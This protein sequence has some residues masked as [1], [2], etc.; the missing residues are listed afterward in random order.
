MITVNSTPSHYRLPVSYTGEDNGKITA[1]LV[2]YKY[3]VDDGSV[4]WHGTAGEQPLLGK[5]AG[6]KTEKF[7]ITEYDKLCED[8][9]SH[10]VD[11]D[12]LRWVL[13]AYVMCPESD[14]TEEAIKSLRKP[15]LRFFS[16]AGF[17][18]TSSVLVARASE[19]ERC[20]KAL[21]GIAPE[22]NVVYDGEDDWIR[23][24]WAIN[25]LKALGSESDKE[26]K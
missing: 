19:R 1:H 20:V 24:K 11:L 4:I 23:K 2:K 25:V 3:E 12:T 7:D 16:L 15:L 5:D 10:D 18:K 22:Y 14:L 17:T 6:E 26:K 9:K 8:M 13:E 21:E